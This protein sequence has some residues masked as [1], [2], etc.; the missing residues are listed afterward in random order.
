MLCDRRMK[1]L[2]FVRALDEDPAA[3]LRAVTGFWA[4]YEIGGET[5]PARG[6]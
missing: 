6:R 4:V 2:G 1:W 3:R 5:L